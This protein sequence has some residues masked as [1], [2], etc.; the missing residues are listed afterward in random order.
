MT[1]VKAI[2]NWE[3][4]TIRV[5][6][7]NKGGPAWRDVPIHNDF[8]PELKTWYEDDQKAKGQF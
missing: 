2:L 6:S 1:D 7:A 3:K 8:L 5:T 4:E